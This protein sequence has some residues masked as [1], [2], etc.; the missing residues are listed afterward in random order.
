MYQQGSRGGADNR[1]PDYASSSNQSPMPTPHGASPG[2]MARPPT[3][4][5]SGPAPH[6]PQYNRSHPSSPTVSRLPPPPSPSHQPRDRPSS[7]YYD[8]TSDSRQPR[9]PIQ[10][11][12]VWY[13][14]WTNACDADPRAQSRSHPEPYREPNGYHYSSTPA[15][16]RGAS[17][18]SHPDP[19]PYAAHPPPLAPVNGHG[20]HSPVTNHAHPNHE[21]RATPIVRHTTPKQPGS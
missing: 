8:P 15:R 16:S 18:S 4:P 20:P 17:Q 21:T 12:L 11:S 7:G 2:D 5:Q 10:V 1:I 6:S 3:Y 19:Y 14:N 13:K 9:S